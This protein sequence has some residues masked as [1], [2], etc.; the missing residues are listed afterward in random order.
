MA[1]WYSGNFNRLYYEAGYI[2]I[3]AVVNNIYI[4][5]ISGLNV[6]QMQ[7]LLAAA[8]AAANA[9]QSNPGEFHHL[10]NLQHAPFLLSAC[11]C[12]CSGK[13]LLCVLHFECKTVLSSFFFSK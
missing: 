10:I 1:C 6:L 12:R 13:D 5:L 4:Y 8:T 3:N 7:Q 9:L 2:Y 11:N